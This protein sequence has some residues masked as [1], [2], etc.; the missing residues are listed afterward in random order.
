MYLVHALTMHNCTL[1]TGLVCRY[2][3]VA[4]LQLLTSF[5]PTPSL[6]LVVSVTV[7]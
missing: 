3:A 4:S 7:P 2:G 1:D 6:R 5:V